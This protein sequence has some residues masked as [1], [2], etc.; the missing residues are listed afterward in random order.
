MIN[1][2]L[3][4]FGLE[5]KSFLGT[6]SIVKDS[7][8]GINLTLT[9]FAVS[10]FLFRLITYHLYPF[11]HNNNDKYSLSDDHLKEY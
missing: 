5:T 8:L 9:L 11:S 1:F 2:V 4:V 7:Q 6:Y 10:P 3:I